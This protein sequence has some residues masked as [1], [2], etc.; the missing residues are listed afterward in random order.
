MT[1]NVFSGTL[2]PT[3]LTLTYMRPLPLKLPMRSTF[4]HPC[5]CLSFAL[6]R[7]KPIDS[8]PHLHDPTTDSW[9]AFGRLPLA[10]A[11]MAADHV[12]IRDL[13]GR[14]IL[15]PVSTCC[16]FPVTNWTD[17]PARRLDAAAPKPFIVP[18]FSEQ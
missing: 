16:A 2:N 17:R 1:Y 9:G 4:R 8:R 5:V 6:Q 14:R 7:R 15:C 3:H 12:H 18:P 10:A 13:V 11:T